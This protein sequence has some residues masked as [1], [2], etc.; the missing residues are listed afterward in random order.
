MFGLTNPFAI[1]IA[2][3]LIVIA[4]VCGAFYYVYDKGYQACESADMIKQAKAA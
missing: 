2:E 4:I 1:K 3:Y